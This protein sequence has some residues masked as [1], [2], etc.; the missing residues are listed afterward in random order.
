MKDLIQR[1]E[2]FESDWNQFKNLPQDVLLSLFSN[3][4]KRN[5]KGQSNGQKVSKIVTNGQKSNSVPNWDQYEMDQFSSSPVQIDDGI[6]IT[7]ISSCDASPPAKIMKKENPIEI[8]VKV[9]DPGFNLSSVRPMQIVPTG[10]SRR[11][12]ASQVGE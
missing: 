5:R 10:S 6:T 9:S 7:E 12:G 11:K 2:K 8:E 1:L 4:R 3:Q